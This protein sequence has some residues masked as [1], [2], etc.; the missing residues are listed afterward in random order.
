MAK[1]AG[2]TAIEATVE[3]ALR[4][5]RVAY[6]VRRFAHKL[7]EDLEAQDVRLTMGGEPTYVGIDE[8]ESLQWSVEALGAL[9]RTQGVAVDSGAAGADGSGRAAALWAGEVVSGGAAATVGVSLYFAEW[10]GLRCGR[11]RS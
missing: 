10:T 11:M 6:A 9:K 1:R 5:G 8:V 4:C 3:R 2:F 7:D